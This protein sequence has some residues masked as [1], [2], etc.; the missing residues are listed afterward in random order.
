MDRRRAVI[1]SHSDSF[2][3]GVGPARVVAGRVLHRW[4]KGVASQPSKLMVPVR[5][6]SGALRVFRIAAIAADC[7]SAPSRFVGSS[8]TAPT[9]DRQANW[10]WPLFRKQSGVRDSWGFDSLSIR[11]VIVA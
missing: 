6:R 8:P 10:W 1:K 2:L 7:N 4:R 3:C 11:F 9:S 5:F